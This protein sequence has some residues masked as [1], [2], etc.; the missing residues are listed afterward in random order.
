MT[1]NFYLHIHNLSVFAKFYRKPIRF[2]VYVKKQ[3]LSYEM[4]YF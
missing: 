4:S 1:N 2:M 3:K